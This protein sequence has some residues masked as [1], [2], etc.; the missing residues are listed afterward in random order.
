[1]YFV[2]FIDNHSRFILVYFLC[3]NADVLSTFQA[4]FA[5]TQT[6]FSSRIKIL[7]YDSSE[8]YM[9]RI[10]ILFYNRWVFSPIVHV[11]T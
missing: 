6:Q 9:S 1:M 2:T 10:F 7:L 3:S 4:F 8:E 5:Y 11:L